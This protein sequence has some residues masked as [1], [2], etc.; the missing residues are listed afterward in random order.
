MKT[1][2]LLP[3][4]AFVSAVAI[5]SPST[6]APEI[7]VVRYGP[8]TLKKAVVRLSRDIIVIHRLKDSVRLQLKARKG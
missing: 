7:K 8:H 3:F 1:L 4:V 2:D 6:A 5:S